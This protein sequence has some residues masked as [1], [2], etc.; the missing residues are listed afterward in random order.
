MSAHT[1]CYAL[2]WEHEESNS[3][4]AGQWK[5]IAYPVC[6]VQIWAITQR[7]TI[8]SLPETHSFPYQM[9]VTGGTIREEPNLDSFTHGLHGAIYDEG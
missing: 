8:V 5:P 6:G 9:H 3:E 7:K 1:A 4:C 2:A